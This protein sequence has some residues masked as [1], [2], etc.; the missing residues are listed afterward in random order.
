MKT[1]HVEWEIDIVAR[2]P[3]DAARRAL[4]VQRDPQGAATVFKVATDRGYIE[5]DL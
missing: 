5:I 4:K 1:Y 3:K 2:G